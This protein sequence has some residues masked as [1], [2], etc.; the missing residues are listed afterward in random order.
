MRLDDPAAVLHDTDSPVDEI[1]RAIIY[2]LDTPDL[3]PRIRAAFIDA[4]LDK[5]NRA[6]L[7]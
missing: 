3:D 4:L 2:C 7:D 5:R 6:T 1:D